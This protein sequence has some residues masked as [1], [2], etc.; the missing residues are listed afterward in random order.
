MLASGHALQA[1]AELRPT[2]RSPGRRRG[3][4]QPP[5]AREW[6]CPPG[7]HG[8]VAEEEAPKEDPGDIALVLDGFQERV[9][10]RLQ[11]ALDG[12]LSDYIGDEVETLVHVPGARA[13]AGADPC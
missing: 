5:F 7:E 11:Q 6:S 3:R 10:Q 4:R 9:R 2:E 12:G 13:T 1:K 8:F